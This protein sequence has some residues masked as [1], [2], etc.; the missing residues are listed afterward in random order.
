MFN[1][2]GG[3]VFDASVLTPGT[4]ALTYTVDGPCGGVATAGLSVYPSPDPPTLT[5]LN[6]LLYAGNVAEG[7]S[8]AWL[9]DFESTGDPV[10][11]PYTDSIFYFPS[12]G[13]TYTVQVIN[14]YGCTALSNPVL[15]DAT[16]GVNH[17]QAE[18]L[19]LWRDDEGQ[20][21]ASSPLASVR[22]FDTF[23]RALDGPVGP[24]P[25]LVHATS[26]D[27]RTARRILR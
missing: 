3:A 17:M 5:P 10:Y 21:Q 7:D 20:L 8:L 4:V 16:I 2:A 11:F 23:G 12:W 24:G 18:N 1:T 6:G 27:G 13:D 14:E 9:L 22:W 26:V 25:W 15:V 19:R